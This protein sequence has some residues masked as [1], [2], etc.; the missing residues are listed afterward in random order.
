MV[1]PGNNSGAVRSVLAGRPWWIELVGTN[2]A[3]N[4]KWQPVSAG[5][6]FDLLGCKAGR[7]AVN[8][9]EF[10]AELSSKSRLFINLQ[11]YSEQNKQNVFNFIPIT[12]YIE[13][14][15]SK[16]NG[17]IKNAIHKFAAFHKA[18]ENSRRLVRSGCA[19]S[20]KHS[21]SCKVEASTKLTPMSFDKR[22]VSQYNRYTMPLCHFSGYNLWLLKPT[23]LNR[24]RGIHVFKDLDR[25]RQL[26]ASHCR[27]NTGGVA[28]S[29]DAA[30]TFVLQ[31]YIERPLL[32]AGRKFDI[33]VW[34]LLTHKFNC[35]FFKEGYLRTASTQYTIDLDDVDNKFV[36][37]TNNAV[38]VNAKNYGSF[39]DGNQMSFKA[40]QQYLDYNYSEKE[41]SVREFLVPAMQKIVK[42]SIL[43]TRKKL[44]NTAA[45]K[46][47][48]EI[49][50]Y[51]FILDEDF[52]VWLIEANTNPCL[53]ESSALLKALIP[54]MLDDAFKLTL[55]CI[56]P[57]LAQHASVSAK[58]YSVEGYGDDENMW[59]GF[60]YL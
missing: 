55:D 2:S 49:F 28:D 37:L 1:K 6:R 30:N 7:Q 41:M 31:K 15:P 18:L 60:V 5:L 24:G 42:K 51:D 35:H 43:A 29:A 14:N 21:K 48:F 23:H 39:E 54:R 57:P 47:S 20:Q 3:L 13:I 4:F 19:S 9:L 16:P 34:V 8:H 52:N 56:F 59:Y 27:E 53:E 46:Y 17:Q 25:L 58:K 44:D 50:G 33:R 38:Q 10:H 40:F 26:M 36:H 11:N 32:V 12:F 45:R 22:A